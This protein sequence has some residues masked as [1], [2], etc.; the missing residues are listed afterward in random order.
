MERNFGYAIA[1]A[2][3]DHS[4]ASSEA[5]VTSTYVRASLHEIAA[6]LAALTGEA[7]SLTR[8][9]TAQNPTHQPPGTRYVG[10]VCAAR[11]AGRVWCRR[12]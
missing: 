10:D 1:C 3:A 6:A 5:G 12:S 4:G 2:Y 9:R 8:T 7:H 11:V